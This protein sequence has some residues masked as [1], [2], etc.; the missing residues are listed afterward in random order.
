MLAP[1]PA[2]TPAPIAS[3][4]SVYRV[5]DVEKRLDKLPPRE[6]ETLRATYERMLEKGAER[7]QVKPSGLPANRCEVVVTTP[8]RGVLAMTTPSR[9]ARA[10]LLALLTLHP[11]EARWA[12][13]RHGEPS[14]ARR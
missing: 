11:S 6:H 2:A 9:P 14:P 5:G 7:F 13:L 10:A 1:A 4:R 3:M 12:S 8:R